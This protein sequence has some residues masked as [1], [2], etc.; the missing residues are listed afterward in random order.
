MALYVVSPGPLRRTQYVW[1]SG[2]VGSRSH[3]TVTMRVLGSTVA[4]TFVTSGGGRA[5]WKSVAAVPSPWPNSGFVAVAVASTWYGPLYT[6][7]GSGKPAKSTFPLPSALHCALGQTFWGLNVGCLAGSAPFHDMVAL[8]V[9]VA[10]LSSTSKWPDRR[11]GFVLSLLIATERWPPLTTGLP[12][13]A[14]P[15]VPTPSPS[16]TAA[17][18]AAAARPR[19]IRR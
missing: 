8:T 1:R 15:A 5:T 12:G 7:A 11:G 13:G 9:T 18:A 14:A 2:V 17:P 10:L 16:A 4:E 3:D 19:L 6:A